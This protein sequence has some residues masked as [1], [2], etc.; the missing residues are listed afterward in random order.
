[1]KIINTLDPTQKPAIVM[2]LAGNGGVGKT[3]FGATAPNPILADAE[4]GSKYL[5]LRGIK[6]DI[7]KIDNWADAKEFL[8]FVKGSE[9]ETVI[10][11]PLDEFMSKL[12]SAIIASNDPKL[13][14]RDGSPTMAGWGKMKQDMKD[15]LKVL[16]DCGKH[17]LILAH[18]EEKDNDGILVKRPKVETKLSADIIDMVDIVGYMEVVEKEGITKRIIRVEEKNDRYIAKDRTGQL[19]SFVEPDFTKIINACQGTE[20]YSWSKSEEVK[21]GVKQSLAPVQTAEK[22]VIEKPKPVKK[23]ATKKKTFETEEELEDLPEEKTVETKRDII[24][25]KL[26]EAKSKISFE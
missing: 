21:S 11:D 22:E 7:A 19:G 15:Y 5:G 10:I 14:Q 1:V 23:V 26:A 24:K 6:M 3:T 9:Y 25:K 12:K 20:T 2:M 13:V 17:V 4:N 8:A 16:R 18:V